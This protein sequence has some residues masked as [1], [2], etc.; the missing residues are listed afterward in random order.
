MEYRKIVMSALVLAIMLATSVCFA[1]ITTDDLLIDGIYRF[2]PGQPLSKVIEKLGQ[3]AFTN[4]QP[5]RTCSHIFYVN[6]NEILLNHENE[7]LTFIGTTLKR[8]ATARG[9]RIG[10]TRDDVL[11]AYGTPDKEEPKNEHGYS[12]L[13]Y[14]TGK[15]KE[16]LAFLMCYDKVSFISSVGD[17]DFPKS[18]PVP[19]MMTQ[20]SSVSSA[21]PETQQEDE[22]DAPPEPVKNINAKELDIDG[23]CPG[24]TMEY[25]VKIYGKPSHIEKQDPFLIYNYN[26]SFIVVGEPDNGNKVFSVAIYEEG[27]KTPSGFTVGTP[28]T[29]VVEKYGKVRSIKIK[30]KDSEGGS[31]KLKDYTYF[32]GD[33]QMVFIVDKEGVIRSIR[34]EEL[35]EEKLN[36][37]LNRKDLEEELDSMP[38]GLG[39]I[40]KR[41]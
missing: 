40:L 29:E 6:G 38:F 20:Q 16:C 33:Q 24:Q 3:P 22:E 34:V 36:K 13:V 37:Y 12:N 30:N 25:V 14:F 10:A 2:Y 31:E 15:G 21:S 4:N 1:R 18:S 26:D 32:C 35:D 19:S 39:Q 28:F 41:L 11:K 8:V 5:N 23:I 27:L 7:R 17:V 9:I